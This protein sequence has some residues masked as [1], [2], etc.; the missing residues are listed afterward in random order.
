MPLR[1]WP[2]TPW[3]PRFFTTLSTNSPFAGCIGPRTPTVLFYALRPITQAPTTTNPFG[4]RIRGHDARSPTDIEAKHHC[5]IF[6]QIWAWPL[7]GPTYDGKGP[8]RQA[9]QPRLLM[10]VP[11]LAKKMRD[12]GRA[13]GPV[14][15][16]FHGVQDAENDQE[17]QRSPQCIRSHRLSYDT[18][19][20]THW[21]YLP[22]QVYFTSS[23]GSPTRYIASEIP[24]SQ[25]A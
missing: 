25:L 24:R 22:I 2:G 11:D 5:R 4:S 14:P 6:G 18:K 13:I 10:P 20:Y 8:Q 15:A 1:T 21:D 17:H 3:L 16:A 7:K 9:L 12:A 19:E 23:S